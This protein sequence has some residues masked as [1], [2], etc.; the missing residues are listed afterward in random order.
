[1][2]SFPSPTSPVDVPDWWTGQL[3][4]GHAVELELYWDRMT[5]RLR[6]AEG[7]TIQVTVPVGEQVPGLLLS[8]AYGTAVISLSGGAARVPVSCWASGE[9]VRLQMIGPVVFIQ[10]REHVRVPIQLPVSLGWVC[11]G[12]RR[13]AHVRS[14]TVDVSLGGVQVAPATTVWPGPG[15]AVRILI[16]FPGGH[17]QLQGKVVGTSPDYGLR[18]LFTDLSPMAADQI[19][20]LTP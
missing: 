17:C 13:G 6:A 8:T 3:L 1:M 16:E 15:C 5:G 14:H 10:R 19:K 9:L 11:P 7:D 12:N 20:K 2:L 18:L 4:A